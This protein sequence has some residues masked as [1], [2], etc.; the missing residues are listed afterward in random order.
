MQSIENED[1]RGFRKAKQLNPTVLDSALILSHAERITLDSSQLQLIEAHLMQVFPGQILRLGSDALSLKE[2][3]KGG[4]CY[5][6]CD[7]SGHCNSAII[8]ASCAMSSDLPNQL[9]GAVQKPGIIEKIVHYSISDGVMPIDGIYL[10][11]QELEPIDMQGSI[12]SN[13]PKFDP[14]RGHGFAASYLCH[15]KR[16][17]L[18]ISLSQ[19]VSHFALTT[20]K[21]IEKY[22]NFVHV[23]PLDMVCTSNTE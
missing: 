19:V 7:S 3:S 17:P 16:T 9:E 18:V 15:N 21:G 8:F 12:S 6:T 1:I 23:L 13:P 10:Y 5:G 14:Y 2:V 20:F 4:V 22:E 11:I